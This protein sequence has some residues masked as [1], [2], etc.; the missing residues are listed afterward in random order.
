MHMQLRLSIATSSDGGS[1]AMN[2]RPAQRDPIELRPGTLQGVLD[3][4]AEAGINLRIAGGRGVEGAG[5]L[6]LAVEDEEMDRLEEVLSAYHV[7]RVHVAYREL[8]DVPGALAAF[9]ADLAAD[10]RL[11]NEIFVGAARDG[12]V[13]VQVT[14]MKAATD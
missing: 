11:V 12:K 3:T 14:T 1:G 10:G 4:I 2:A 6:V 13:P 7:H 5:E 8:D 9:I